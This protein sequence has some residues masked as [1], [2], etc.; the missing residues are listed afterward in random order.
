MGLVLYALFVLGIAMVAVVATAYWSVRFAARWGSVPG[1]AL[2]LGR[3]AYRE[4]RVSREVPRGTPSPITWTA[5]IGMVWSVLTSLVFAPMMLCVGAMTDGVGLIGVVTGVG[6][7]VTGSSGFFLGLALACIAYFVLR[8]DREVVDLAEGAVVWSVL[9]HLS[10]LLFVVLH[11]IV[12]PGPGLLIL[13]APIWVFGLAH[14][15][16]LQD[17]AQLTLE[18]PPPDDEIIAA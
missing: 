6:L 5:G 1:P 16:A 15:Y 11:A 3:G 10:G 13:T 8:R 4:S 17:A 7:V 9:H 14:A 2:R 18:G 12:T